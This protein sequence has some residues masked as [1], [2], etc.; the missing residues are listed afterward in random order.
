MIFDAPPARLADP[1]ILSARCDAT[2]IVV[3]AAR[4]MAPAC[5]AAYAALSASVRGFSASSSMTSARTGCSTTP[6][7]TDAYNAPA[8]S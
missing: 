7:H 8:E 2:L 1:L 6:G 3:C 4:S 5:G